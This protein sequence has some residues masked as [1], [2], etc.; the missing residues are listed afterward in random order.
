MTTPKVAKK[1]LLKANNL[2]KKFIGKRKK[3]NSI[4]PFTSLKKLINLVLTFILDLIWWCFTSMYRPIILISLSK[5][6]IFVTQ[7]SNSW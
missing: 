2:K 5:N 1:F 7:L 4:L 3:Q 6:L